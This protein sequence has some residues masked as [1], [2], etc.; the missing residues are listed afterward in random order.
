MIHT[1]WT[2]L[3]N[4]GIFHGVPSKVVDLVVSDYRVKGKV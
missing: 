2:A 1:Q 3:V 4:T